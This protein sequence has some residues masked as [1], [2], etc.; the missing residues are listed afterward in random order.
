MRTEIYMQTARIGQATASPQRLRTLNL[1]AQR[2]HTV[3]ELAD[4][5]GESKA[6]T[7]AH[8]KVLR[9]ACLVVD[10]RRGREVWCR[11]GSDDVAALLVSLRSLAEALLPELRDVI[12]EAD[13][14]PDALTGVSL[15]QLARDV[16]SGRVRLLDLRPTD[17][18]TFG[19][20]PGSESTPTD[21]LTPKRLRELLAEVGDQE[22]VAYCR[23]PWCVMAREGV[24][25]LRK[26]G[27]N[28][29]RLPAG[30]TEWRA[31]NMKLS[32]A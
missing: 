29:K 5:L 7:S 26:A 18:F 16:K 25:R 24:S 10:E 31:Q 20:L 3:G 22:V 21:T 15:R 4:R 12:R 19:H 32:I 1:L 6:S 17:E 13:E 9:A 8:L 2:P 27:I 30:V 14:D 23:G 28:A 11:L